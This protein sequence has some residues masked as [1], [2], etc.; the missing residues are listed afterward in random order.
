MSPELEA[1]YCFWRLVTEK[2]FSPHELDTWDLEEIER[3]CSMLD[4]GND[5]QAAY[6]EYG[7]AKAKAEAEKK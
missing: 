3:A 4:M 1:D 7:E 6:Q 2:G 5:W